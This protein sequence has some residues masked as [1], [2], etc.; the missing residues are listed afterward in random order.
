M[1]LNSFLN[2]HKWKHLVDFG[3]K[4]N[5]FAVCLNFFFSFGKLAAIIK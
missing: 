5:Y 4:N 1:Y 2:G 3:K